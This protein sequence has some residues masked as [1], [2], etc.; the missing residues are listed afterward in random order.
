MA[1]A[2]P[3]RY[4]KW[5]KYTYT[6][7]NDDPFRVLAQTQLSLG[8]CQQVTAVKPLQQHHLVKN[9]QINAC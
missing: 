9:D 8:K 4:F 5:A 3:H 1:K 7:Q 6:L 2:L